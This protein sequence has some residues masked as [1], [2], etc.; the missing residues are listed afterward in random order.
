MALQMKNKYEFV[1]GSLPQPPMDPLFAA[2]K[3]YN[4]PALSW[5]NHASCHITAGII[6]IDVASEVWQDLQ[7]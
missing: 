6:W 2:W 3:R 5:F 7:V 4:A 1:D